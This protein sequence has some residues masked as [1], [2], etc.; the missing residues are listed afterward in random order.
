MGRTSFQK[1]QREMKRQEKQRV[2]AEKRAQRKVSKNDGPGAPT[3]QLGEVPE[4]EVTQNEVTQDG[5]T[6]TSAASKSTEILL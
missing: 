1:R 2:K 4:G 5:L 3:Q 6:R